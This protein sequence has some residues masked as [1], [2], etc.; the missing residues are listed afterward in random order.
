MI[1]PSASVNTGEYSLVYKPRLCLV[2]YTS[3]Y[4][5]VF[6]LALGT[7]IYIERKIKNNYFE[8]VM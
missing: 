4:S 3:E 7:I 6:T 1:V 2:L 5:P 8:V